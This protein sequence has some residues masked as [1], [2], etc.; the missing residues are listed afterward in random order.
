M[1]LLKMNILHFFISR[2]GQIRAISHHSSHVQSRSWSPF[3]PERFYRAKGKWRTCLEIQLLS[4]NIYSK[5]KK[6]KLHL[7]KY[8]LNIK[9]LVEVFWTTIIPTSLV[10]SP[11]RVKGRSLQ[12]LK[13]FQWQSIIEFSEIDIV[14]DSPD[15]ETLIDYPIFRWNFHLRRDKRSQIRCLNETILWLQV[16]MNY[17]THFSLRVP[18]TFVISLIGYGCYCA[19]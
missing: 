2:R 16:K 6:S 11:S 18:S 10:E 13:R 17:P 14:N 9:H 3:L 5:C 7:H 1:G 8:T 12:G 15:C 19:L 4:E